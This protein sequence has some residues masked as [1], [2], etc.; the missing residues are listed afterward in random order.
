MNTAE[1][2]YQESKKLPEFEAQEVLD[3]V[4]FLKQN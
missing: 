1:L 4:V 3:F 2:I